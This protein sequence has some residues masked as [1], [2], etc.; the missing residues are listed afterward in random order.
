MSVLCGVG[1]PD[2]FIISP[3]TRSSVEEWLIHLKSL[4]GASENTVEA[5]RGDI[6]VFLHFMGQHLNEAVGLEPLKRLAAIDMRAWLASER[7]RGVSTRSLARSLSAVKSFFR[8]L[9]EREDFDPT[10]ILA[11][12][13]PKFQKKL[14]RPLSQDAAKAMLDTVQT[15]SEK[16]WVSARDTAVLTVLYGCGLRISEALSLKVN[17][18]PLPE[19]LQIIGKGGKERVMP[20]L[21]AARVAVDAYLRTLPFELQPDDALF[22][23]VRG[24]PLSARAVQKVVETARHQLG[25]P[26]TVTPHA[27]R[28]SFATHLLEAGGDLRTIQ[29]LLGHASLSTTQAYTAVDT[30]HLMDVYRRAHPRA[31]G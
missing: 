8:W 7:K 26:A 28:H 9:A 21:D 31:D 23:G 13:S 25:L 1:L 15:Q 20:V 24:G 16:T 29:E 2:P 11:T 14:P 30:A 4:S 5:Y 18:V 17:Q 3:A 19:T 10:P 27:L 12:R 22:R 6:F